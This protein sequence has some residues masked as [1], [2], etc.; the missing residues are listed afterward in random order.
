LTKNLVEQETTP[1]PKGAQKIPYGLGIAQNAL[2][3]TPALLTASK[4]TAYKQKNPKNV[5][6]GLMY[7]TG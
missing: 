6:S 2:N 3:N 5:G 7:G 4:K 1:K